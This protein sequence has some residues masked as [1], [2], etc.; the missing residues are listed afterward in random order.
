MV[1]RSVE[2]RLHDIQTALDEA[3]EILNDA[4]F[5]A[6]QNSLATRRAIE[7]CIEIISEATRHIPD[8]MTAK[9]PLIPW[10]EIRSIG[11]RLRHEYQRVDDLI[12]WRTARRSLPELKIAIDGLIAGLA[13]AAQPKDSKSS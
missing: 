10:Q 5:G 3:R 1:K 8:E 4:D 12:I 9:Y 11:I 2:I 7:R 6:Y 13:Q